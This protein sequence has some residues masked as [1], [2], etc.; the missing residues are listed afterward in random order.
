[1][2]LNNSTRSLTRNFVLF[3]FLICS[4]GS[5]FSQYPEHHFAAY[6]MQD[7]VRLNTDHQV[8][9]VKR[10][11]FVIIVDLPDKEGVFVN[12][13]F[14]NNT[15]NQALENIPVRKLDGFKNT[16][17]PELWR[18]PNGEIFV[19]DESPCYWFIETKYINKFSEYQYINK[20]YYCR[21]EV[22]RFYDMDVHEEKHL[23]SMISPVYFTLIKFKSIEDNKRSSELM[24]HA[25][26]IEWID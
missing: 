20:R 4:W 2:T 16:G 5:V 10:K 6:V 13:S 23:Y 7:G 24:R 8:V 15:F 25:F 19:S 21:R 18:N 11:P 9:K 1:M 22:F 3:G 14:N 26:K 12:I 17:L